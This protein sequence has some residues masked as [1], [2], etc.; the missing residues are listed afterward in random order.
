ML[1]MPETIWVMP[2]PRIMEMSTI[3]YSKGEIIGYRCVNT[4]KA[5]L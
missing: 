4:L 2:I 3:T 5:P 1:A